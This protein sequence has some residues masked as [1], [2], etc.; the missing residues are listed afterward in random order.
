MPEVSIH[1]DYY[2]TPTHLQK[3]RKEANS[4]TEYRALKQ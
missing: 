2:T 3:D 4:E 1:K